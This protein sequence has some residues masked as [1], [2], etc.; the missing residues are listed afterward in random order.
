MNATE[1]SNPRSIT[2]SPWYWAYVFCTG[3][4]IVLITVGPRYTQRQTQIEQNSQKRQWAAQ[5][6]AGQAQDDS[7][8]DSEELSIKLWPL[9]VVLS[10]ILAIAWCKLIRDHLKRNAGQTQP[11]VAVE[12]DNGMAIDAVSSDGGRQ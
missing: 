6:L 9:F 5:G 11:G 1:K 8:M 12:N 3:G 7:R 10:S 2:E 4:L